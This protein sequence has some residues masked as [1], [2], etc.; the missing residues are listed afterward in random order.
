[1]CDVQFIPSL[2][3]AWTHF[4]KAKWFL[5]VDDD[6]Y[7]IRPSLEQFLGHFDPNAELYLGNAQGAWNGRFAHG[8]SAIVISNAAMKLLFE[9]NP[10][11]VAQAYVESLTTPLGDWHVAAAYRKLGLWL[12]EG[13]TRFFN[14]E[15]PVMSKISGDRICDPMVSFHAMKTPELMRETH[16]IFGNMTRPPLWLD[17]WRL[18]GAPAFDQL[19]REPFRKDWNHVGVLDSETDA[20]KGVATAEACRAICGRRF[21]RHS[22]FAWMYDESERVCHTSPWISVGVESK[23]KTTGVNVPLVQSY[24]KKC[25]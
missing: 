13:Y 4:P 11:I 5:L 22:C 25:T 14:G 7:L 6:T 16:S 3:L 1:M 12:Q 18:F 23:G 24:A 2:E 21:R 20:T 9:E 19:E 8:G 15:G 17:T 10:M